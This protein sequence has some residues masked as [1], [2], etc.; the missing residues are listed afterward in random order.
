MLTIANFRLL[1][2]LKEKISKEGLK[3]PLGDRLLNIDGAGIDVGQADDQG[4]K[5][6]DRTH[7]LNSRQSEAVDCALKNP[8]TYV[9]GPPGTGKTQ[10]IASMID[11]YIKN[12]LSVLLLSHTNIATDGALYRTAEHFKK[13]NDPNLADGRLIRVGNI[14]HQQ[15]R[16]E[17]GPY[18]IKEQ[19]VA[20]L[21]NAIQEK[22]TVHEGEIGQCEQVKK[23]ILDKL[24]K[25]RQF[26]QAAEELKSKQIAL[27]ANKQSHQELVSKAANKRSEIELNRQKWEAFQQGS[28]L[29]RLLSLDSE[30]RFTANAERLQGEAGSLEEQLE[31]VKS[32]LKSLPDEISVIES[33][34]ESL[35]PELAGH[36]PQAL[37]GQLRQTENRIKSLGEQIEE[38]QAKI[39]KLEN[40]LIRRAKLIA[41][42]LTNS[43]IQKDVLAREYDCVIIDEVSMALP[44]AVWYAASL[45]QRR[46]VVIGDFKQLPPIVKH[47]AAEGQSEKEKER[48]EELVKHWLSKDIFLLS[49]L[50]AGI[51]SEN[52]RHPLPGNLIALREQYRMQKPIAD[53][54]NHLVYGKYRGGA[55]ALET[56]T[57]PRKLDCELLGGH[58]LGVCDTSAQG[59]YASFVTN[60]SRSWYCIL[61]AILAVTLAEL[62]LKKGYEKVGIVTAYRP[63]ANLI[64]TILEDK[65]INDCVEANTVHKFQGGERPLMIF[66]IAYPKSPSIYDSSYEDSQSEKL[67]NVAISRTQNE[68]IIL[69]DIKRILKHHS[70]NSPIR[71][72]LTYLA[73]TKMP[74]FP[75]D[76]LMQP[77]AQ[78]EATN[79]ALEKIQPLQPPNEDSLFNAKNFY[80]GF[81]HDVTCAEEEIIIFSPYLTEHR[82]GRVMNFLINAQNKGVRVSVVTKQPDRQDDNMSSQAWSAM[83]QMEEAGMVVLP[84]SYGLHEKVAFIDRQIYWVGSLNIL[85]QRS[86]SEIMHRASGAE[87]TIQQLF[88]N[89]SLDKNLGSVGEDKLKRCEQCQKPGSWIWTTPGNYGK[90]WCRC[91]SCGVSGDSSK[92]NF[93]SPVDQPASNVAEEPGVGIDSQPPLCSK[94]NIPMELRTRRRDGKKFWGCPKYG[95]LGCRMTQAVQELARQEV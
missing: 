54:V 93:P 17:F 5:Q 61:N 60:G 76:Q 26:T 75:S 62:A 1:E 27:E 89:F 69:G 18:V 95:K 45:A 82:V 42:T 22:I 64:R 91:L 4:W 9:W 86:S 25:F 94:H 37:E 16:E 31:E 85:S 59:P 66:D 36:N 20:R 14:Q 72:M 80:P 39:K 41:T 92:R 84:L 19:V 12:G 11:S 2:Q 33:R 30:A 43:Y 78:I 53:L 28:R 51:E 88:K 47:E 68:C 8:V 40:E 34:L 81:L 50:Q 15:L 21:A 55:F 56:R 38:L 79:A 7:K 73:E 10:A 32:A 67:L 65:K 44:P 87:K 49:G 46:V 24:S 63:Q 70:Q 23:A 35:K 90:P 3:S 57:E 29:S 74:F 71:K 58:K 13:G 48:E 6:S 83:R 52:D 77:A